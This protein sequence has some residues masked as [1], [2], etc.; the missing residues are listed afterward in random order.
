MCVTDA[1]CLR[2]SFELLARRYEDLSGRPKVQ[3]CTLWPTLVFSQSWNYT[4]R[5]AYPLRP[6]LFPSSCTHLT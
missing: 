2:Q 6:P 1:Q 4:P 5:K 3:T